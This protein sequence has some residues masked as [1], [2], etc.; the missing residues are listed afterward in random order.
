MRLV[1]L[2]NRGDCL[3]YIVSKMFW[4]LAQPLSLS[5]F[6]LVAALLVGLA[7][8]SGLRTLLSLLSALILF[9][10]LFTSSGT[11]ALQV[12]ED[13]FPRPE[14]PAGGRV[15]SSCLAEPS[16]QP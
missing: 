3:S 14:L 8:W 7:G 13:R 16:K 11:V 10:T 9:V 6:L 4:L 12:L 15:A 5:F 1:K 2:A